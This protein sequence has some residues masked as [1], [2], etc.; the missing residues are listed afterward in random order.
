MRQWV[1]KVGELPA[2][3]AVAR[4]DKYA[5]D[6]R[7]GPF[8]QSLDYGYATFFVDEA[9]D[10]QAVLD[11]VNEVIL[12]GTSPEQAVKSAADKVQAMLDEYWAG[13]KA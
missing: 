5:R 7:L 6:A 3:Q 13:V 8:L 2:R 9:A 12:N 11:A 1:E 10:R 4:E